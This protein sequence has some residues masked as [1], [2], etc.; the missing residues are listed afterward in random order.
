[1]KTLLV[2]ICICLIMGCS[3]HRGGI[4]GQNETPGSIFEDTEKLNMKFSGYSPL[5]AIKERNCLYLGQVEGAYKL[6]QAFVP[7]WVAKQTSDATK[8]G[9]IIKAKELGGTHI[10]WR[11]KQQLEFG[12]AVAEGHVFKCPE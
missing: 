11:E 8:D 10:I 7:W 9:A 4:M 2:A 3:A 6:W 12:M 5:K 1:M